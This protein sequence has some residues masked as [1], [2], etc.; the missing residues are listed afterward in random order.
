MKKIIFIIAIFLN[1][2]CNINEKKITEILIKKVNLNIDTAV[3]VN[4]AE[5]D[6]SF[7]GLVKAYKIRDQKKI[8]KLD[9]IMNS[10][11]KS[12]KIENIDT[13]KK[14]IILYSDNSKET[15]CVDRFGVMLNGNSMKIDNQSLQF[16]QNL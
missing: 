2:G 15:L 4:C 10:M 8:K 7:K 16:I 1:L 11:H 13:R 3:R 9:S 5:F 6:S 14:I 12:G